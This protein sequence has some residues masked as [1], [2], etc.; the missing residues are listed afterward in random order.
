MV[1]ATTTYSG[2]L[3]RHGQTFQASFGSGLDRHTRAKR[4]RMETTNA[5][6]ADVQ[7]DLRNV[8]RGLASSSRSVECFSSRVASE[9]CRLIRSTADHSYNLPTIVYNRGRLDGKAPQIGYDWLERHPADFTITPRTSYAGGRS[10][11]YDAPQERLGICRQLGVNQEPRC[12]PAV[13]EGRYSECQHHTI[14]C[15]T[16]PA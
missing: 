16:V 4:A 8:Q 2:E 3:Q 10:Y 5:M 12:H 7:I 9:V 15:G 1:S 14:L 13:L 11:W 6:V